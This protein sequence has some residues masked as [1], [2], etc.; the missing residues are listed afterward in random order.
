MIRS[1]VGIV[2]GVTLLAAA[3]CKHTCCRKSTCSSCPPASPLATP[4][5][6]PQPAFPVPRNEVLPPGPPPPGIGVTPPLN[7]TPSGFG[8]IA[9]AEGAAPGIQLLPP[10]LGESVEQAS[11]S[12]PAIAE[13]KPT[14]TLPVG[15]P[16]FAPA[17]ANK[18][19]GGRKPNLDGLDWLKANGYR[20]VLLLR[21][22]GESDAADRRQFESRG[23]TFASLEVTL[24]SLD[25]S[26]VAQFDHQVA[27]PSSQPLFV[28]D[29]DGSLAGPLWYLHFRRV[30]R[31]SDEAA[32]AK[33]ERLGLK[34]DDRDPRIG[35]LAV[36]D[37]LAKNP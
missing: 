2:A 36:Q 21:K 37:F 29:A 26:T 18:V 31:L 9:S 35:W 10:Q 34:L 4:L 33:A 24:T 27:N 8:A 17:I 28:Y 11:A 30:E 1:I 23:L 15:I 20:S 13:S 7:P 5:I 25:R 6:Q 22:A 16:E 19:T 12:E 14:P 3:G 32:R